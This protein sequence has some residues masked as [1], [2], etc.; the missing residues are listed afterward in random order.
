MHL[1]GWAMQDGKE[2]VESREVEVNEMIHQVRLWK[3]IARRVDAEGGTF[4]LFL[5]MSRANG[6]TI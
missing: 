1:E 4:P 5:Q 3:G 2:N 6:A